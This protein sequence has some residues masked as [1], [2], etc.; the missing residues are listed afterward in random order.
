MIELSEGGST[1]RVEAQA[2]H[3]RERLAAL[4]GLRTRATERDALAKEI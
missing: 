4:A 2:Y 1:L 3:A